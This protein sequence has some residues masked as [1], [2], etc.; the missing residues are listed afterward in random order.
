[1]ENA[2]VGTANVSATT[3]FSQPST[4]NAQPLSI[5]VSLANPYAQNLVGAPAVASSTSAP[6]A[7]MDAPSAGGNTP[8]DAKQSEQWDDQGWSYSGTA[9]GSTFY[10]PD[11]TRFVI[12]GRTTQRGRGGTNARGGLRAAARDADDAVGTEPT[13]HPGARGKSVP[14]KPAKSSSG[15]KPE[16]SV[17]V[18][19]NP[20]IWAEDGTV[21]SGK[22]YGCG[23]DKVTG[24][25][26]AIYHFPKKPRDMK[27][28]DLAVLHECADIGNT[29]LLVRGEKRRVSLVTIPTDTPEPVK[30]SISH[31]QHLVR[32]QLGV[33]VQVIGRVTKDIE[34]KPEMDYSGMSPDV[35]EAFRANQKQMQVLASLINQSLADKLTELGG[36]PAPCGTSCQPSS[37]DSGTSSAGSSLKGPSSVSTAASG[38]ESD[39]GSKTGKSYNAR[40]RA[41]RKRRRARKQ[42][43]AEAGDTTDGDTTDT[44]ASV[45][46]A[47][48]KR[49]SPSQ[50][51]HRVARAKGRKTSE[52]EACSLVEFVVERDGKMQH[53]KFGVLMYAVLPGLDV[54]NEKRYAFYVAT[55]LHNSPAGARMFI[56]AREPQRAEIE[57]SMVRMNALVDEEHDVV[58]HRLSQEYFSKVPRALDWA[59][60]TTKK[61]G[62]SVYVLRQLGRAVELVS[63]HRLGHGLEWQ[64]IP[65][66]QGMSGM[67]ILDD[68]GY[69]VGLLQGYANVSEEG[70]TVQVPRVTRMRWKEGQPVFS[71]NYEPA[72]VPCSAAGLAVAAAPCC[73]GTVCKY[74]CAAFLLV[75]LAAV[76]TYWTMLSLG[77][78]GDSGAP[79][80]GSRPGQQAGH[81]HLDT[82]T[83]TSG[84]KIPQSKRYF[85]VSLAG[86][87]STIIVLS[88]LVSGANCKGSVLVVLMVMSFALGGFAMQPEEYPPGLFC[89]AIVTPSRTRALCERSGAVVTGMPDLEVD[90]GEPSEL[91]LPPAAAGLEERPASCLQLF[92][93]RLTSWLTLPMVLYTGLSRRDSAVA[94]TTVG[95]AV[96]TGA[97][98]MDSNMNVVNPSALDLVLPELLNVRSGICDTM[99]WQAALV[100]CAMLLRKQTGLVATVGFV[101][102]GSLV[103][104]AHTA[105]V[106]GDGTQTVPYCGPCR[107]NVTCVSPTQFSVGYYGSRCECKSLHNGPYCQTDSYALAANGIGNGSCPGSN[108]LARF[109]FRVGVRAQR[110]KAQMITDVSGNHYADLC[111]VTRGAPELR[112]SAHF[113]KLYDAFMEVEMLWFKRYSFTLRA[114]ALR[115]DIGNWSAW[116]P[117]DEILCPTTVISEVLDSD[118]FPQCPVGTAVTGEQRACP[119]G[120]CRRNRWFAALNDTSRRVLVCDC[121]NDT[122]SFYGFEN[123]EKHVIY[124]Q[125]LEWDAQSGLHTFIYYYPI[126]TQGVDKSTVEVKFSIGGHDICNVT[127]AGGGVHSMQT[128]TAYHRCSFDGG[129]TVRLE[130]LQDTPIRNVPVVTA[131]TYDSAGA[132]TSHY[133]LYNG[134]RIMNR[135]V[136]ANNWQYTYAETGPKLVEDVRYVRNGRPPHVCPLSVDGQVCGG[137]ACWTN[138]TLRG[139][140]RDSSYGFCYCPGRLQPSCD[141]RIMAAAGAHECSGKALR[142]AYSSLVNQACDRRFVVNIDVVGS[143]GSNYRL[144][145]VGS[146]DPVNGS[147]AGLYASCHF[148]SAV[149]VGDVVEVIFVMNWP[150]TL[151]NIPLGELVSI[152]SNGHFCAR[153]AMRASV[154]CVDLAYVS[155][156]PVPDVWSGYNGL[157]VHFA[158]LS[159]TPTAVAMPADMQWLLKTPD[160]SADCPADSAGIVC[161]GKLCDNRTVLSLTG[162][163]HVQLC[164]CEGDGP[165][166]CTAK[167]RSSVVSCRDSLVVGRFAVDTDLRCGVRG[168]AAVYAG[169]SGDPVC[170]VNLH[171]EVQT[172]LRFQ[173]NLTDESLIT[174]Y[175]VLG[176]VYDPPWAKLEFFDDADLLCDSIIVPPLSMDCELLPLAS[177]HDGSSPVVVYTTDGGSE[178]MADNCSVAGGD[179]GGQQCSVGYVR[180]LDDETRMTRLCRC[181][182]GLPPDCRGSTSTDLPV[183]IDGLVNVT[184]VLP[185]HVPAGSGV[186]LQIFVGDDVPLIDVAFDRASA[187]ASVYAGAYAL[188]K[189]LSDI[190]GSVAGI[191]LL[192]YWYGRAPG[193]PSAVMRSG[194]DSVRLPMTFVDCSPL[195][196]VEAPPAPV[197][198]T[199]PP[200]VAASPA[201]VSALPVSDQP[202]VVSSTLSSQATVSAVPISMELGVQY[203]DSQIVANISSGTCPVPITGEICNGKPCVLAANL[204]F[205][206]DP[207]QI[208]HLCDCGTELVPPACINFQPP[209]SRPPACNHQL[210]NMT[211]TGFQAGCADRLRVVVYYQSLG[212]VQW[213]CNFYTDIRDI[214]GGAV[215]AY[216]KCF[217]GQE[218]EPTLHFDMYWSNY[219]YDWP[220]ARVDMFN[221]TNYMC[222]SIALTPTYKRCSALPFM[223]VFDG[224]QTQTPLGNLS[225]PHNPDPAVAVAGHRDDLRP[226]QLGGG[227]EASLYATDAGSSSA[228]TLVQP[229][230]TDWLRDALLYFRGPREYYDDWRSL[231]A[232]A[233]DT[234]IGRPGFLTWIVIGGM[235]S[236]GGGFGAFG[237]GLVTLCALAVGSLGA[238]TDTR[239]FDIV[240]CEPCLASVFNYTWNHRDRYFCNMYYD[241]PENKEIIA[242]GTGEFCNGSAH[243]LSLVMNGMPLGHEVLSV[244]A[245]AMIDDDDISFHCRLGQ[246]AQHDRVPA[247]FCSVSYDDVVIAYSSPK[248]FRFAV[249]AVTLEFAGAPP[250][251]V[252]EGIVTDQKQRVDYAK[253]ICDA[254]DTVNRIWT[255]HLNGRCAGSRIS[256]HWRI[257]EVPSRNKLGYVR[258]TVNGTFACGFFVRRRVDVWERAFVQYD[259]VICGLDTNGL[260]A[261]ADWSD[262]LATGVI[263]LSF[264]GMCTFD[265]MLA[266]GYVRGDLFSGYLL[267]ESACF[268]VCGVMKGFTC[269]GANLFGS[270]NTLLGTIVP[271]EDDLSDSGGSGSGASETLPL[272]LT[273]GPA[274][275]NDNFDLP[276]ETTTAHDDRDSHSAM[277]KAPSPGT[278]WTW[279][280]DVKPQKEYASSSSVLQPSST[281][282]IIVFASDSG[283]TQI[284]PDASSDLEHNTASVLSAFILGTASS[285]AAASGIQAT[286]SS[287]FLRSTSFGLSTASVS[288]QD[289]VRSS[290]R[291]STIDFEAARSSAQILA[292]ISM[293]KYGAIVHRHKRATTYVHRCVGIMK[294]GCPEH[295]EGQ[296]LAE[297]TTVTNAPKKA[298]QMRAAIVTVG[299]V[300]LA[301][302]HPRAAFVLVLTAALDYAFGLGVRGETVTCPNCGVGGQGVCNTTVLRHSW[303]TGRQTGDCTC[304]QGYRGMYCDTTTQM[305]MTGSC[306]RADGFVRC[307]FKWPSVALA[308]QD[309][310]V[311]FYLVYPDHVREICRLKSDA[312]FE[313][314]DGHVTSDADTACYCSVREL[315][316]LTRMQP[317]EG[318]FVRAS[319]SRDPIYNSSGGIVK[320]GKWLALDPKCTDKDNPR[321]RMFDLICECDAMR[322]TASGWDDGTTV[323]LPRYDGI[324][325]VPKYGSDVSWPADFG[326]SPSLAHDHYLMTTYDGPSAIG[327]CVPME[328]LRPPPCD[329][330]ACQIQ[331]TRCS[332]KEVLDTGDLMMRCPS[333]VGARWPCVGVEVPKRRYLCDWSGIKGTSTAFTQ[334]CKMFSEPCPVDSVKNVS[335]AVSTLTAS[336][337]VVGASG[338]IE[339]GSA[340]GYIV[341]GIFFHTLEQSARYKTPISNVSMQTSGAPLVFATYMGYGPGVTARVFVQVEMVQGFYGVTRDGVVFDVDRMLYLHRAAPVAYADLCLMPSLF[342]GQPTYLVRCADVG[343][344][345]IPGWTELYGDFVPDDDTTWYTGDTLYKGKP[346]VNNTW[347]TVISGSGLYVPR[348]I[349]S[350]RDMMSRPLLSRFQMS[351]GSR[352]LPAIAVYQWPGVLFVTFAGVVGEAQW[353]IVDKLYEKDC[354]AYY[355]GDIKSLPFVLNGV[356]SAYD[357]LG[358]ATCADCEDRWV[359]AAIASNDCLYRVG[360]AVNADNKRVGLLTPTVDAG[361]DASFGPAYTTLCLG[362]LA[363]VLVPR[364]RLTAHV[365][366]NILFV[367]STAPAVVNFTGFPLLRG[368]RAVGVIPLNVSVVYDVNQKTAVIDLREFASLTTVDQIHWYGSVHDS[369][370]PWT[371]IFHVQPC[372]FEEGDGTWY[373]RWLNTYSNYSCEHPQA[374]VVWWCVFVAVLVVLFL[375]FC[376]CAGHAGTPCAHCVK[377]CCK[378][379]YALLRCSQKSSPKYQP[380]LE[381]DDASPVV[382]H[383][384]VGSDAAT[385][386]DNKAVSDKPALGYTLVP[387]QADA[388]PKAKSRS[389]KSSV[390]KGVMLSLLFFVSVFD[391]GESVTQTTVEAVLRGDVV[392]ATQQLRI[393]M[394]L[395]VG[396][397][398]AVDVLPGKLPSG[399]EFYK[400][401]GK[402]LT[403]TVVATRCRYVTTFRYWSTRKELIPI[404]RYYCSKKKDCTREATSIWPD[405]GDVNKFRTYI[406]QVTNW[407]SDGN[408]WPSYYGV[409]WILEFDNMGC[410]MHSQVPMSHRWDPLNYLVHFDV[411]VSRAEADIKI[412]YD[413]VCKTFTIDSATNKK[414]DFAGMEITLGN[415]IN[416]RCSIKG[417]YLYWQG[418]VYPDAGGTF[419]KKDCGQVGDTSSRYI[420]TSATDFMVDPPPDYNSPSCIDFQRPSKYQ[421]CYD[422]LF[423]K[424]DGF[425]NFMI[426]K[427]KVI[428]RVTDDGVPLVATLTD[429]VVV[430]LSSAGVP[431]DAVSMAIRLDNV[432]YVPVAK[433]VTIEDLAVSQEHCEVGSAASRVRVTFTSSGAGTVYFACTPLCF[434]SQYDV[435]TGAN[436]LSVSLVTSVLT[437]AFQIEVSSINSESRALTMNCELPQTARIDNV[438]IIDVSNDKSSGDWSLDWGSWASWLS[439]LFTLNWGA[440]LGGAIGLVVLIVVVCILCRCGCCCCPGKCGPSCKCKSKIKRKE[441]I[442]TIGA[443][444]EEKMRLMDEEAPSYDELS[445]DEEEVGSVRGQP[446]PPAPPAKKKVTISDTAQVFVLPPLPKPRQSKSNLAKNQD[447]APTPKPRMVVPAKKA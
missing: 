145:S 65:I 436:N 447:N 74:A 203:N 344:T 222:G 243:V 175:Y 135:W 218:T 108:G 127:S 53:V 387:V 16:K 198:V 120:V 376:V 381:N 382:V 168:S 43:A 244:T 437:V 155:G 49:P 102:V 132:M 399:A 334:Q 118:A 362:S 138:I 361:S 224:S 315:F 37:L 318:V 271:E 58:F 367:N 340:S 116:S 147:W 182:T 288:S 23:F 277:Y 152:D 411:T 235:M 408:N 405:F 264:Y 383:Y 104:Y 388:K 294:E 339:I 211:F 272:N 80:A 303:T 156:G 261:D 421:A 304:K 38:G 296:R 323:A 26:A 162:A 395:V 253:H 311:I 154:S 107:E 369:G 126:M 254:H 216:Y 71:K 99:L 375:I 372:F 209:P 252:R 7:N 124:D 140:E 45:A 313:D 350:E 424:A 351:D 441:K 90:L 110:V 385:A 31:L 56:A 93:R 185:L 86:T 306:P 363:R 202:A 84:I 292:R 432:T 91:S 316:V 161:A 19:Q 349:T 352:T 82:A 343:E 234:V 10:D 371:Y 401:I 230:G 85:V 438:T 62:P 197:P 443:L 305:S 123:C 59:R 34:T 317:N 422:G 425:T 366:G 75:L 420:N 266:D 146:E 434:P 281:L 308:D 112:G 205:M 95:L 119:N 223:A 171:G 214:R 51:K 391:G 291:L 206:P 172:S 204:P 333:Y 194:S 54:N 326:I 440:W 221:R 232:P 389:R 338:G 73:V 1:M 410:C 358:N 97:Q 32:N 57:P 347:F 356:E 136:E 329:D 76:I 12:R 103:A 290:G 113:C 240:Y 427:D 384:Q 170:T 300:A 70:K 141:G 246:P 153:S 370:T 227:A 357:P 280:R 88:S 115:G 187:N 24:R 393:D 2:P 180:R 52:A 163:E 14:P 257:P 81:D 39:T 229:F 423:Q 269:N 50:I 68:K 406:F 242:A 159:V 15:V 134:M 262:A 259:G 263:R 392:V 3:G 354:P 133:H 40:R 35:A 295:T 106:S 250:A 114:S 255:K 416:L 435:Q 359:T 379:C 41:A 184:Y 174:R 67:P 96:M 220:A 48:L 165:L 137:Y 309:V 150:S 28:L 60:G 46:S 21:M 122:V 312:T 44:D 89:D 377:W 289:D 5:T 33:E 403:V 193:W 217:I 129:Q 11:D 105:E 284:L 302:V 192:L 87:L 188:V 260:Y 298:G 287:G 109:T 42:A 439:D 98:V 433:T 319:L 169:P 100:T 360:F 249:S 212:G 282:S 20:R 247:I 190:D 92:L 396:G 346:G 69:F 18:T 195:S 301:A 327:S 275:L 157:V 125:L 341:P 183:C 27:K 428:Q 267:Q 158:P 186:Q 407:P 335:V 231:Y 412:C 442:L 144:C 196:F 245:F 47:S 148:N 268:A 322:Y 61:G 101:I 238:P 398:E 265:S 130:M 331:P 179:C 380:L 325:L 8:S 307:T 332:G 413:E 374:T 149:S 66:K 111:E 378:G 279:Q 446:A 320:E 283:A 324:C 299:I 409:C 386:G 400:Y 404:S 143:D 402:R 273:N 173:C 6:P 330:P 219:M 397:F 207:R 310:D 414:L 142:I 278:E 200:L 29:V 94:A 286:S 336:E 77:A 239:S 415:V 79:Y 213:L 248:L 293:G 191:T 364:V 233:R 17:E 160:V 430:D 328:Y 241:A 365:F 426:M 225:A 353:Y 13:A 201:A 166:A 251:T 431:G 345:R 36:R 337:Y 181:V 348:P 177:G 270:V 314:C 276:D 83:L 4:A 164:D 373:R 342:V 30:H 128:I 72:E 176:D 417:S 189:S 64:D 228:A 285:V 151:T 210:L 139:Y 256:A 208:T 178:P 237:T 226:Q 297:T 236:L 215:D 258:I 117:A 25:Y 78:F 131:K 445:S 368:V 321:C 418:M 355:V 22:Q 63:W 9:A 444:K 274:Y 394:P 419:D 390:N 55:S 429:K 199:E 167:H 121:D